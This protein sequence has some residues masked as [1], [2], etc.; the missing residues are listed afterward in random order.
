MN[1]NLILTIHW[2]SHSHVSFVTDIF[3]SFVWQDRTRQRISKER[4]GQNT[5]SQPFTVWTLR[6][7]RSVSWKKHSAHA[8]QGRDQLVI[9][10]T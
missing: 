10:S 3:V 8:R 5:R 4:C 6:L 1:S 7:T 9:A 2:L